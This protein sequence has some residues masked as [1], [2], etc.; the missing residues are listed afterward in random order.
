MRAVWKVVGNF[1]P[2]F[3]RQK[4]G[5]VQSSYL[6]NRAS[7]RMP[8]IPLDGDLNLDANNRSESMT[9][10]VEDDIPEDSPRP[11]LVSEDFLN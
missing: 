10:H 6:S 8:A 4:S 2:A 7:A 1:C 9:V 5:Q 11:K 3:C